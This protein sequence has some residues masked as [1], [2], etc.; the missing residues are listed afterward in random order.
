[1]EKGIPLHENLTNSRYTDLIGTP[2]ARL[3]SPIK[4]YE[5]TS[6]VSLEQAVTCI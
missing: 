3:L 2:V 6:L 4:V 1:M 5:A